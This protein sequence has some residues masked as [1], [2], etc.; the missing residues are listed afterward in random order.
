M[1]SSRMSGRT[2][3]DLNVSD[4]NFLPSC[5]SRPISSS[6]L[7]SALLAKTIAPTSLYF[8][9]SPLQ[10]RPAPLFDAIVSALTVSVFF[11]FLALSFIA[12][13][14][15]GVGTSVLH[16]HCMPHSQRWVFWA[17]KTEAFHAHS[18]DFSACLYCTNVV[19]VA[20]LRLGSP[21][22]A[23]KIYFSSRCNWSY[24]LA[25]TR[26]NEATIR[27]ILRMSVWQAQ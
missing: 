3:N 9:N 21:R 13:K 16:T 17:Q 6:A 18:A 23:A 12:R 8:H 20:A 14:G 22:A 4:L 11:F 19:S 24:D 27:I 1:V 5:L 15:W 10:T 2:V 25:F 7:P 26:A